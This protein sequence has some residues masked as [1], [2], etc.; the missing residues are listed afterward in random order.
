MKGDPDRDPLSDIISSG[1][2]ELPI[3][4][5]DER[6]AIQMDT[7]VVSK[8]IEQRIRMDTGVLIF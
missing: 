3:Y 1:I 7:G 8:T 2:P 5:D 6:L 4:V